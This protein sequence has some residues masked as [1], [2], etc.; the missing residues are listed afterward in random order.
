MFISKMP[1][2]I[3]ISREKKIYILKPQT[4]RILLTKKEM[5]NQNKI[6]SYE[7]RG[8]LHYAFNFS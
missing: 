6:D 7:F 8:G 4:Q 3:E 5:R 2:H 1:W